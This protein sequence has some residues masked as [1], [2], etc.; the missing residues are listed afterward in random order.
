MTEGMMRLVDKLLAYYD[1]RGT[2]RS[3]AYEEWR[4]RSEEFAT[5]WTGA[6]EG[7]AA[8]TIPLDALDPESLPKAL[9][10]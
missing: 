1:D 5:Q 2:A 8:S 7:H 3:A 6:Y 9:K 10:P 4:K